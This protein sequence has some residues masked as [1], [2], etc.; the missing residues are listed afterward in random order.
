MLFPSPID[1]EI[2]LPLSTS[3]SVQIQGH[4]SKIQEIIE[5]SSSLW[6][7]VVG[8]CSLHDTNSALEYAKKLKKLQ[9][10]VEKTCLLVLRAHVEKPRTSLGWKGLL[11][12]P[13]LDGSDNI[14]EGLLISREL[15]LK[16]AEIGLP[17][18]TEFLEPLV[19]SYFSDLVSWGFIGARTSSSQIHRQLA[20][21]LKLPM[22]FKNSTDGNLESAIQ[23]AITAQRP[24]KFI[25]MNPLGKI[26]EVTSQ[27]NPFSHIVLRGSTSGPNYHSSDVLMALRKLDRRLLIDCAHDNSPSKPFDQ[28]DVCLNALEQYLSGN[29]K[30]M[31]VMLESHLKAGNQSISALSIDP[32]ISLTDPCM[33]WEETEELICLVHEALLESNLLCLN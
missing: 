13:Y 6:A 15:Y 27:G 1:L 3:T 30:I 20:S 26:A 17:I 33:G 5:G 28:R 31:G 2:K 9:E 16:I 8:P 14:L 21:L 24:H 19:S 4:R 22:G 11:Y 7:F 23:G 25:H 12:D 18:A 32:S 29:G 10:K